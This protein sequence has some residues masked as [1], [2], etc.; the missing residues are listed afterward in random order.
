[1]AAA[2]SFKI[3]AET[4]IGIVA[5]MIA[6]LG[7]G[8]AL[9]LFSGLNLLA[10]ILVFLLVE[11][12]KRRSLEDLDLVFAVPKRTFVRFQ[13]QTYLPWFIRH[14][15]SWVLCCWSPGQGGAKDKDGRARTVDT[16]PN[17]YIDTTWEPVMPELVVPDYGISATAHGPYPLPQGYRGTRAMCLH[18]QDMQCIYLE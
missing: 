5:M 10:L 3:E 8:G 11:E 1:M 4:R 13:V 14:Y 15:F 2:V 17:L 6:S 7:N 16:K 9:G 18:T 12:T